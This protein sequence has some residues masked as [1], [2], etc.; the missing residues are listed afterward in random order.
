MNLLSARERVWSGYSVKI[1]RLLCI[2][3][4][5]A[6]KQHVHKGVTEPGATSPRH[7]IL[8]DTSDARL[9]TE[10]SPSTK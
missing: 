2:T 3:S 7:L 1:K 6:E 9:R 8:F 5:R 4:R 10:G